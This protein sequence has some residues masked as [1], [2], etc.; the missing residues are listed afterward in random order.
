MDDVRRR[1]FIA[2]LGGAAAW[3]VAARAQQAAMPVIG[4]LY[5]GAPE[6][7]TTWVAAFR[8]GLTEVGFSEGRNVEIEFRWA[9]NEP[10]RLPE[11]AADLVRRRVAVI[12]APG[13]SA[14][15]LA[16]R[17]ATTTIPIVFRT[18]GDPVELGLVASLNRP[19]GNVTGVN[20]MSV[21]TGTK[22]LGLLH[23]LL[24]QAARFAVLFNP[25][26]PNAEHVSKDLRAAA[27]AIGR[28]LDFLTASSSRDIDVAFASLVQKQPDALLVVPQG[29]LFNRRVQIVTQATRHS[30]PTIYPG[31][32][33]AE[34]GGLMSYGASSTEQFRQTGIY[35][36]RVL[37]G[38]KPAD[39]P[40]LRASKFEFV[41][42]L[43]TAKAFGI[44]I[45]V[46]WPRK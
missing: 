36:G 37:K 17:A 11:L 13:T 23:E 19:G 44:D 1:E 10:E 21:E 14:S 9:N 43:Q 3:P 39:L 18:G 5:T 41:I 32:E 8:K 38:E 7:S 24:P 16:A 40:V 22:R 29:L 33:F 20:A 28:Q 30:L 12:V 4:Y 15:V 25:N 31:R 45:P 34:I 35:T 2:M 6:A 26:D 42:N 27:L 46:S